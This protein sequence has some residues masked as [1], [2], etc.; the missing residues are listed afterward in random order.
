MY[1][2]RRNSKITTDISPDIIIRYKFINKISW[3]LNVSWTWSTI[4]THSNYLRRERGRG[5]NVGGTCS[6]IIIITFSIR[7]GIDSSVSILAENLQLDWTV[8]IYNGNIK[9]FN[10]H[11]VYFIL[12]R[13]KFL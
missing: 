3:Y 4:K 12:Y 6:M 5:R 10:Y 7:Y 1:I 8:L 13:R 11:S 2:C 9:K